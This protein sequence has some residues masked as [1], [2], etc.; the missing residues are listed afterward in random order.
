MAAGFIIGFEKCIAHLHTCYEPEKKIF[1]AKKRNATTAAASHW[2]Y[3]ERQF[4]FSF[5]FALSRHSCLAQTLKQNI[6]LYAY[7]LLIT[8]GSSNQYQ[9]TN[10]AFMFLLQFYSVIYSFFYLFFCF[11]SGRLY[12]WHNAWSLLMGQY[13]QNKEEERLNWP[14]KCRLQFKK[15]RKK[16]RVQ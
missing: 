6:L 16:R 13:M 14:V 12:S 1:L 4:F 8:I 10:H 7:I 3:S 5:C 15:K 2:I 9:L 11:V